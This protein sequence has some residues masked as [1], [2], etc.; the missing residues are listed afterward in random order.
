MANFDIKPSKWLNESKQGNF[1]FAPVGNV[2]NV[3]IFDNLNMESCAEMIAQLSQIISQLPAREPFDSTSTKI[4]SPYD[5][6]PDR[7][8]FDVLIN[9][10]GGDVLVYNGISSMF[11]L[12]K[13][14][15][16]II[17]TNNIGYAAS[18]ASLL[19]VQGTPGYRIMFEHAYNLVHYGRVSVSGS[20][21][22]ELEI[23]TQNSKKSRELLFTTYEKYTKL[24]P[25]EIEKYK[26]VEKSGQLFAKQCLAKRLCDWILTSDGKLIGH[27]R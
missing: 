14:R 12:A 26:T 3:Q 7:F 2:C 23:A 1:V 21:E 4:T 24:T 22:N 13:S 25:E 8:V 27:G 11:A 19:A 20:R 16:A 17:R 6:A 5:I 18:C 10:P 9:A 15:G